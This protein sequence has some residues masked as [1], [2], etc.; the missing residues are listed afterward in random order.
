MKFQHL[1]LYLL[2]QVG[3]MALTRFLFQW[4]L[5]YS[6]SPA[7]GGTIF[8]A[9]T[10]GAVMLGFRIFD[11]VT[12]P[13][14][15]ALSDWWVR[16]GRTRQ[17]LLWY[18]VLLPPIGLVLCFAADDTMS[19]M[20]R[21]LLLI[22][23][24][25]V[26]F[27]GYTL[28]AI[29]YWSLVEDYG[30]HSDGGRRS[31]SNMLGLGLIIATI[32]GFVV[33]PM[34]VDPAAMGYRGGA[35]L[36]AVVSGLCM[37][38]PMFAAPDAAKSAAKQ[39]ADEHPSLGE[40]FGSFLRALSNRRFAALLALLAGSQ[41]SFTVLTAAAPFI[42]VHLLAGSE[43]DVS[44]LLGPL[45]VTAIPMFAFAPQIS[46]RFG[47]ERSLLGASVLLGIV[48]CFCSTAGITIVYSPLV[49]AILLFSFA[50]PMI[51]ILLALEGEAI[52]ACIGE[53]DKSAVSMY[54]G[55]YNLI[56][57]AL[58]GVAMFMTGLLIGL[59]KGPWGAGAFR[60]MVIVS[61]VL[62]FLGVIVSLLIKR[63]GKTVKRV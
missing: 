50:G 23:G 40:I 28:Y 4:L 48:Y 14:A 55:V 16:R 1:F 2:G 15:G 43:K 21:W 30:K 22:S 63:L 36:F 10:V 18:S 44:Y 57:K 29:P 62:L 13:M 35:I 54:F 52:T 11:G 38:G 8:V 17:S 61:A 19:F 12:D 7:D 41:M 32:I 53:R 34:I 37:I 45:I 26:F 59:S 6:D 60:F 42:A 5:K 33:S 31:L 56:I 9:S 20:T 3:M 47:W 27:V 24:L 25:I 49:S 58:N 39:T 46:A 51:A